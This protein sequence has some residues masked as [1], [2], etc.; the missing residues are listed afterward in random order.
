MKRWQEIDKQIEGIRD[1]VSQIG[2]A[3]DPAQRERLAWLLIGLD[4]KINALQWKL[5]GMRKDGAA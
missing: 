5:A 2:S 4:D 3:S 1:A